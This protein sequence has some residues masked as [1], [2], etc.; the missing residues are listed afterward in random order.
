VAAARDQRNVR[1]EE[2]LRKFVAARDGG[3]ADG[4]RYWWG[5]LAEAGFDRVRGMVDA[6]V[7]RYGF[8]DDERQEAVQRALVKLW[9]KMIHSF[10][11]SSMG[12]LANATSSLVDFVCKD[13]QRGA[14]RRTNRETGL[15]ES[16]EQPHPEWKADQLA[17]QDHQRAGEQAEAG[18]FLSWAVPRM[19]NERQRLVI[20]R[21]LDGVPAEE[22]AAELEVSTENLYQLRSRGLRD[23]RGLWDTWI[24]S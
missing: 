9:D 5:K 4:A 3:D 24:E 22:I 16:P 15:Y 8:S 12:E 18:D 14:A 13:V 2:L 7:W 1:E 17:E 20:E 23:L 19:K 11:G 10:K 6:R 21:T